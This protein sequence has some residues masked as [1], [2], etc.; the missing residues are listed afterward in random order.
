MAKIVSFVTNTV[1]PIAIGD[2]SAV[3]FLLVV[4]APAAQDIVV[5]FFVSHNGKAA[6]ADQIKYEVVRATDPVNGADGVALTGRVMDNRLDDANVSTAVIQRGDAT[7]TQVL[8][9]RFVHPQSGAGFGTFVVKQGT[10]IG[11]R[12]T[13]TSTAGL[14]SVIGRAVVRE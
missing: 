1:S 7:A 12:Y 14:V 13:Q 10:T 3:R 5:D 11:L 9:G 4:T 6:D 8:D 2:G